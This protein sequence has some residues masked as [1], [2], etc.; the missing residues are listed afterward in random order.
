[1]M[2]FVNCC[3]PIRNKS[4]ILEILDREETEYFVN[5]YLPGR[6]KSDI[7]EILDREEAEYLTQRDVR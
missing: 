4:D 5:S 7:L 6:N 2:H 3:L 1:M